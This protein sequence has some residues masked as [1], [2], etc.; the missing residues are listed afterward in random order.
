M[1]KFPL[2]SMQ[3]TFFQDIFPFSFY[4]GCSG[5]SISLLLKYFRH[6]NTTGISRSLHTNLTVVKIIGMLIVCYLRLQMCIASTPSKWNSSCRFNMYKLAGHFSSPNF[7]KTYPNKLHCSW[8]IQ[9]P[10]GCSVKISFSF[11]E[12]SLHKSAYY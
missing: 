6:L 11:F 7:P 9:V 5:C 8:G 4:Q 10:K 3:S 1:N 2:F 12:V